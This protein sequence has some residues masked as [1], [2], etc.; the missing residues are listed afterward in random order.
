[1]AQQLV[2]EP[3][4]EKPRSDSTPR[5]PPPAPFP[6]RP[7]PAFHAYPRRCVP[8]HMAPRRRRPRHIHLLPSP[9]PYA[10]PPRPAH[11]ADLPC[12]RA[13]P[14]LV[15]RRR[16]PYLKRLSQRVRHRPR[17]IR[18][19]SRVWARRRGCR[20][21]GAVGAAEKQT[22]HGQRRPRAESG[23][24]GHGRIARHDQCPGRLRCVFQLCHVVCAGSADAGP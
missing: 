13:R 23:P 6:V 24:E 8:P 16:P 18:V 4:S 9:L 19:L 12:S 5:L 20:Q 11:P 15:P 10:L 14:P 22:A 7:R 3:C 2:P 21:A 1:M 17:P